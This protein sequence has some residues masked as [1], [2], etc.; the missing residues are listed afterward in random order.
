MELVP[1]NRIKWLSTLVPPKATRGAKNNQNRRFLTL[2]WCSAVVFKHYTI[3]SLF[4]RLQTMWHR[5]FRSSF[6]QKLHHRQQHRLEPW[7][8]SSSQPFWPCPAC[9]CWCH[10]PHVQ[11]DGGAHQG[12]QALGDKSWPKKGHTIRQLIFNWGHLKVTMSIFRRYLCQISSLQ[13][14]LNQE[15]ALPHSP[16]PNH[17][18]KMSITLESLK[19]HKTVIFLTT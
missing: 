1:L 4:I 11:L 19:L 12:C 2:Q 5:S 14:P 16:H 15:C 7:V 18:D 6:P 3:F 9:G 17:C 10:Q 13:L 8:S